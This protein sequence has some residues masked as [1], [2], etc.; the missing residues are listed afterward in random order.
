[1]S[2]RISQN[3]SQF[4]L[5][6]ILYAMADDGIVYKFL[7]NVHPKTKTPIPATLCSGFFAALMAMIFDVDHLI[8][9]MNIGTLMAYTIVAV[10]VVVLHYDASGLPNHIENTEMK[11]IMS[12]ILN[13][14]HTK[15]ACKLTS[16]I[17][18][19]SIV[20]FSAL[21]TIISVIMLFEITPGLSVTI[22]FIALL[23]VFIICVIV[24]QPK[25]LDNVDLFFKVPFVPLVPCVS[26]F[27]NIYLMSLLSKETWMR[28]VVWMIVGEL[29]KAFM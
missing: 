20:A 11:A 23:M 5:P 22:I 29:L 25:S 4:P 10:C 16:G 18:N 28:F 6:R 7:R 9:M 13:Y 19:I 26:I 3:F 17:V 1:M 8:D 2:F 24:C 12:Q 15:T 21:S 14:K 27:I